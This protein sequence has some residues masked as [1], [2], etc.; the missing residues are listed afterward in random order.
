M[1]QGSGA[2]VIVSGDTLIKTCASH[3]SLKPVFETLNYL[4]KLKPLVYEG[5]QVPIIPL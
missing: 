1:G 3:N 2:L 5:W 4:N